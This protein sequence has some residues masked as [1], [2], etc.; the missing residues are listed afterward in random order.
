MT[1][2]FQF[3]PRGSVEGLTIDIESQPTVTVFLGCM[4][5]RVVALMLP[6]SLDRVLV[7]F[8]PGTLR[9]CVVRAWLGAPGIARQNSP[10]HLEGRS[11]KASLAL[12]TGVWNGRA[13]VPAV[14][15]LHV[16]PPRVWAWRRV[17]IRSSGPCL[18]DQVAGSPRPGIKSRYGQVLQTT[19]KPNGVQSRAHR[20]WSGMRFTAIRPPLHNERQ[21]DAN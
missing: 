14:R 7:R 19:P 8:S 5:R 15:P 3:G 9:Y 4:A 11:C 10:G 17:T 21:D 16:W 13:V 2:P 12:L 18:P 6:P 20:Q 1:Q